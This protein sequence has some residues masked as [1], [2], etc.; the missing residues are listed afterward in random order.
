MYYYSQI[1]LSL[2][3]KSLF[4]GYVLTCE[5]YINIQNTKIG[6]SIPLRPH[7]RV[8]NNDK[9]VLYKINEKKF[10]LK[11]SKINFLYGLYSENYYIDI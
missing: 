7:I 5:E 10:N 11:N 4:V 2:N 6:D 9:C 3:S 8:Q 1:D